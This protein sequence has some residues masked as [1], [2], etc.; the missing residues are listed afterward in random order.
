[1]YG[2]NAGR[3]RGR[4]LPAPEYRTIN[5]D[6]R[7]DPVV[8]AIWLFRDYARK[9]DRIEKLW[10]KE[11]NPRVCGVTIQYVGDPRQ[12]AKNLAM[13]MHNHYDSYLKLRLFSSESE[14]GKKLIADGA[15]LLCEK[16]AKDIAKA[17]KR[18]AADEYEEEEEAEGS[19]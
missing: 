9:D 11:I 17:R 8:E 5:G 12:I 18:K 15:R 1:M 10:Y 13:I 3:T 14:S 6:L 7:T 19:V 16:K 4:N 2:K